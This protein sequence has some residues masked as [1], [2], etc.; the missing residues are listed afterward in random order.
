MD[1]II[2][3]DGCYKYVDPSLSDIF[4]GTHTAKKSKEKDKKTVNAQLGI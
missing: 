3:Y 4:K 1:D 2:F